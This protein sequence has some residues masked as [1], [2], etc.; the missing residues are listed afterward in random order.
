MKRKLLPLLIAGVAM[1]A[2]AGTVTSKGKD[3]ELDT[4]GGFKIRTTD[5][6]F[7]F[8]LGGRMQWDVDHYEGGFNANNDGRNVTSQNLRRAR[9]EMKGVV[10]SDWKWKISYNFTDD[11]SIDQIA[12]GYAGIKGHYFQI[13]QDKEPIGLE[14][15]GSSK[16]ITATER[17][18]FW[19]TTKADANHAGLLYTG[20][21]GPFTW[22]A[23]IFDGSF[24]SNSGDDV[25]AKTARFTYS[26][27]AEKGNVL[28]FGIA[29]SDR[30]VDGSADDELIN[31]SP[32][33]S[34][35]GNGDS[36]NAFQIDDNLDYDGER[37]RALEFLYIG[38]PLSVQAEH[39]QRDLDVRTPGA[40]DQ[41]TTGYY[42]TVAYTLTGESRGYKTKAA[43]PDKIKPSR[44]DGAWEIFARY[45]HIEADCGS[46]AVCG[47]SGDR[48]EYNDAMDVLIP[49]ENPEVTAITLGVNWYVNQSVKLSL[50]YT[51]A[52]SD[53]IVDAAAEAAGVDD[54][55]DALNFRAQLAF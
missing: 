24:D 33:I 12:F 54:Q 25:F 17:S 44:A 4:T 29:M 37:I 49:G 30:D 53:D 19:D 6:E 47:A 45:D 34:S 52:E 10:Y 40:S 26:P 48:V 43:V 41:E 20:Y 39:F 31:S 13:G 21:E 9:L 5:D 1:N 38:G 28:H 11:P 3:L 14:E 50:N 16:W 15:L 7:S 42:V 36:V 35:I 55:G 2:S 22:A 27:I 23:G 51:M 46:V 18:M 8:N 32:G